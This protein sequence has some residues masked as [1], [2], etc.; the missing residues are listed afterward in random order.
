M[1]FGGDADALVNHRDA[2]EFG[3]RSSIDDH[4]GAASAVF[5]G[6]RDEI[7]ECRDEL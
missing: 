5:D 6:V 4:R 2:D 3:S 7:F 1:V